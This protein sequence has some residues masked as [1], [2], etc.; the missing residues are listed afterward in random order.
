MMKTCWK[1]CLTVA[2][3]A[4]MCAVS[5]TSVQAAEWGTVTGR[6]VFDG[7]VPTLTAKVK[8]GDPAAKDAEVCAANDV[9]DDSLVVNG[10][11]KGVQ[12]VVIYL[13]KAPSSI[14]PDLSASSEKE[15]VMD[16]KGCVFTPHTL[17]CR[18]DQSV[19]CKN[20]DA[21]AHNVR[22]APFSNSAEN[23]IV[24]PSDQQGK[25][26]QMKLSE[27]RPVKVSCDIHTYMT[28]WWIVLD[29]PY[30]AITDADGNFTI[31]NLPAGKHDFIIWQEKAGYLEKKFT[32]DV[33]AGDNPVGDLKFGADKFAE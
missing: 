12:H 5:H 33:K 14:H 22:T 32:V 8:K 20:S 27:S 19:V 6:I 1:I 29:H 28:G 23:F 16:Q 15:V 18:T 10:D 31:E 7:A 30:A 9:P 3:V 26:V 21:V 4:T 2:V 17:I 11:N 25:A 13:R 24:A